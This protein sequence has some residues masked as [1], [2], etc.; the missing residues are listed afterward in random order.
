MA[1]VRFLKMVAKY[2]AWIYVVLEIVEFA[3][4]KF[5]ALAAKNE[6]KNS[7]K[8]GIISEPAQS[9]GSSE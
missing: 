3:T 7:K 6:P 8:D 2:G 4:D 9:T 1:I 5:E